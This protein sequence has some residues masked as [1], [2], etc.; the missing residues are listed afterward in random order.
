MKFFCETL[1]QYTSRPTIGYIYYLYTNLFSLIRFCAYI[2][3]WIECVIAAHKWRQKTKL[4]NGRITHGRIMKR[5]ENNKLARKWRC[6]LEIY[7]RPIPPAHPLSGVA[8]TVGGKVSPI[9]ILY[10]KQGWTFALI[11]QQLEQSTSYINL[12][13]I[14]II[15]HKLFYI[16]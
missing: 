6:K 13:Y 2:K 3:R 8:E 10:E 1:A 9:S 4:T 7:M 15:I 14:I 11:R 12:L 5:K 16:T